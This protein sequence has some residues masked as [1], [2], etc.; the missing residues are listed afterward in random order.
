MREEADRIKGIVEVRK[1]VSVRPKIRSEEG[2]NRNRIE[3]IRFENDRV[4]SE[5][6]RGMQGEWTR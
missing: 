6:G 5:D 2:N 1:E 4:R 3:Q